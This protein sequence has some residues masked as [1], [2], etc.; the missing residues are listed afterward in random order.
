MSRRL[1]TIALSLLVPVA[2]VTA[3][4]PAGAGLS[5][6][7]QEFC[8]VVTD[9]GNVSDTPSDPSDN[10]DARTFKEYYQE[11]ADVAP[12][13]S[14]KKAALRAADYYEAFAELDSDDAGDVQDFLTSSEYRKFIKA[15]G[16]LSKYIIKTCIPSA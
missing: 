15:S 10:S 4:I 9:S 11:I 14:I 3:A 7:E 1:V 13:K 8:D 5:D 6:A 2:L 16:K 12:K